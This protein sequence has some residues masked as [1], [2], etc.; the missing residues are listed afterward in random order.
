MLPPACRQFIGEMRT[1]AQLASRADEMQ[2][3]FELLDR[4]A[5]D[6]PAVLE[7][8]AILVSFIDR[9][10]VPVEQ[11]YVELKQLLAEV[12]GRR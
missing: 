10:A 3:A 4:A 1:H 5:D 7:A 6:N 12:T 2:Q 8:T 9:P 11:R